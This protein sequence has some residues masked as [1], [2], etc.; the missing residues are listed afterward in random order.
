MI[1]E[2]R[3]LL[4]AGNVCSLQ[5]FVHRVSGVNHSG[6]LEIQLEFKTLISTCVVEV[7]AIAIK[8]KRSLN[9]RKNA[10]TIQR[11]N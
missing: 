5:S 9:I 3:Q 11:C 1:N 10:N 2:I 4:A 6:Q 7:N 8:G